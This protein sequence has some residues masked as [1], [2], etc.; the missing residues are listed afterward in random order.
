MTA[1]LFKPQILIAGMSCY[2][3]NLDYARFRKVA[4][5]N[6]SYLMAD[7][8]HVAGLVA[9][10]VV[11]SP[12]QHCDIVTSTV[13]KTL[14]GPRAGI[15]FFRR[16]SGSRSSYPAVLPLL[17]FFQATALRTDSAR[18]FPTTSRTESTCP[19]SPPS[20]VD[21][22]ITPSPESLSPWST[23]RRKSSTNTRSRWSKT[24][25]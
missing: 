3:R 9:A 16:G 25:R 22:T 24:H 7:M 18:K 14:R 19:S 23:P 21:P 5:A 4:D 6:G 1:S 15:I 12:F 13:H 20:R 10:K 2:S 17:F 8:A 11:P